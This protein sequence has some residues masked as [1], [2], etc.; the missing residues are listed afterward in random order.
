MSTV[1]VVQP[2]PSDPLERW[3]PWLEAEGLALRVVQ[4]GD[5]LPATLVED[6]LVVLGGDMGVHDDADHPWLE[7]VRALLRQGVERGVP[8]LGICLGAQLLAHATGGQVEVGAG[9]VEAGVVQV[10]VREDAADDALLADLPGPFP[11]PTMHGDAVV[12]LPP[13]AR[14]L[15]SSPAYPH[16]AFRLGE[17]AWGLQFHP[18][19]SPATYR[20][21]TEVYRDLDS[22]DAV[23]ARAGEAALEAADPA[24]LPV[25][26]ELARR[27]ARLVT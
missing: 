1:L 23:R 12:A 15:A 21:W 16:Q 8:T 25:A 3:A 26:H 10:T 5:G 11:M 20:A 17:R 22:A 14:W 4:P 19:I 9:G 24:V 2:D 18:E 27:F 7:D 6:G 13:A